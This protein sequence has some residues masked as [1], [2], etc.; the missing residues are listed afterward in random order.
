MESFDLWY[1][2][3]WDFLFLP[4]SI[5]KIDQKRLGSNYGFPVATE[6][7]YQRH[8]SQKGDILHLSG[9]TSYKRFTA[10]R[11]RKRKD[12]SLTKIDVK[13]LSKQLASSIL[14]NYEKCSVKCKQQKKNCLVVDTWSMSAF[15][16]NNLSK[17]RNGHVS[18]QLH[19]FVLPYLKRNIQNSKVSILSKYSK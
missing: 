13:Q 4:Q 16:N 17:I 2:K 19:L 10:A 6:N 3:D 5:T 8:P 9:L 12:M 7:S 14:Q 15:S 18:Q 11:N 1:K